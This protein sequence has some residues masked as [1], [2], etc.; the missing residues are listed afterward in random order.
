MI[1]VCRYNWLTFTLR[2]VCLCSWGN[3]RPRSI[4]LHCRWQGHA[5]ISPPREH[6]KIIHGVTKWEEITIHEKEKKQKSD[7]DQDFQKAI[8]KSYPVKKKKKS[9]L[10]FVLFCFCF[11]LSGL[12]TDWVERAPTDANAPHEPSTPIWGWRHKIYTRGM[13]RVGEVTWHAPP[14]L[15]LATFHRVYTFMWTIFIFSLNF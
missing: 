7:C 10:N 12:C 1:F 9:P 5:A 3:R 14:N 6:N 13:P 2:S 4:L 8:P 11:F 15:K